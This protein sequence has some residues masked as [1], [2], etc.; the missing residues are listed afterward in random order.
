MDFLKTGWHFN[1]Q[2]YFI[3]HEHVISSSS[4]FWCISYTTTLLIRQ[5]QISLRRIEHSCM[6]YNLN[7]ILCCKS[8]L[9]LKKPNLSELNWP[10]L[11]QWTILYTDSS[12]SPSSFSACHC[13][14]VLVFFFSFFSPL[15]LSFRELHLLLCYSWCFPILSSDG[16]EIV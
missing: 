4:S 1:L 6:L 8:T 10:V 15:S 5:S 14:R 16:Q 12:V 3:L 9:D 7:G 13:K 2:L 11:E